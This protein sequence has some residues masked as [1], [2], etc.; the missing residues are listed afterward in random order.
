MNLT[1]FRPEMRGNVKTKTTTHWKLSQHQICRQSIRYQKF[2]WEYD[3]WCHVKM[4]EV[5]TL[6]QWSPISGEVLR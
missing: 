2:I 6:V 5:A 4:S 3:I 1:F